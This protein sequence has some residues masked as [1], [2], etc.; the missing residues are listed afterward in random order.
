MIA[1]DQVGNLGGSKNL[2]VE[3]GD[4]TDDESGFAGFLA[5][6]MV[7]GGAVRQ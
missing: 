6:V 4:A 5:E 1:V 7:H 2:Y 3:G